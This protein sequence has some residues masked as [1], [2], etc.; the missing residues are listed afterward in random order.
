MEPIICSNL[1]ESWREDL[2]VEQ[3]GSSDEAVAALGGFGTKLG[4]DFKGYIGTE[5]VPSP[6]SQVTLPLTSRQQEVLT[7]I[8]EIERETGHPAT[9][10]AIRDRIGVK[11]LGGVLCHLEA[12][13][14]KG[15]ITREAHGLRRKIRSV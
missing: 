12:L 2:R 15:A 10:R 9:I 5:D 14:Y 4:V 3:A 6:L 1:P 11:S 8:A 7:A 13:E